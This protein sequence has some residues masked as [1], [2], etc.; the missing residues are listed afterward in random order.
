M[1]LS[2][3]SPRYIIHFGSESLHYGHINALY[4]YAGL[5]LKSTIYL[6]MIKHGVY[7][8]LLI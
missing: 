4:D 5:K 8:T 7:F 3:D 2:S 1:F 6:P